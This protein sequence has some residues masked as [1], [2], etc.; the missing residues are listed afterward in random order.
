MEKIAQI[1]F[2]HWQMNVST[3]GRLCDEMKKS[4]MS[5]LDNEGLIEMTKNL[6]NEVDKQGYFRSPW[7]LSYFPNLQVNG[8]SLSSGLYLSE[9]ERM[10]QPVTSYGVPRSAFLAIWSTTMA[11]SKIRIHPAA[12]VL[13]FMHRFSDHIRLHKNLLCFRLM[14]VVLVQP[15]SL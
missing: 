13:L 14:T 5:V 12:A 3:C 9:V 11:R 10:V 6:G 4:I 15:I 8:S 2:M 1:F 7:R